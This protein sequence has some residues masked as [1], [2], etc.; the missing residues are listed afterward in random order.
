MIVELRPEEN[1]ILRAEDGNSTPM[2]AQ[3]SAPAIELEP[4]TGGT[5]TATKRGRA[6]EV[7]RAF[8]R[9]GCLSFGG[10][11]AHL[12][13][14][15]AEFVER[16]RWCDEE[17][18]GEVVALAQALPGPASS[19]VGFA[20]GVLRAGAAGGAAAWLGF[21]MPSALLMMGFAFGARLLTGRVGLGVVHGL[22]LVAVA[23]VAQALM[24]MRRSLAADWMRMLLAA[25][26]GLAVYFNLGTLPAIAMGAVAGLA[27][28]RGRQPTSADQRQMWGTNISFVASA[29]AAT[30]FVLLLFGLPVA[31]ALAGA[32]RAGHPLT[33]EELA[34]ANAFYRTGA[35]VF[36][37]GHVVLPLLERSVVQP[38]WVD[39]STFLAGYG[40]AQAVPGPLF[41]FSAFLGA[42]VKPA[43][44]PVLTA[45]VALA[46]IFLPGLLLMVAVLPHW[47][48]LRERAHVQAALR[49]VNAAVVGVLASAFVR[50]VWTSA[51]RSVFDL[52]IAAGAFAL[53]V[54]W[55]VAPWMMVTGV[56]AVSVIR[57]LLS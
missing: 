5:E 6:G 2:K 30:A 46:S 44:A 26:A 18:F 12:G 14:F 40:A 33:A 17:T 38:G 34:V 4:T 53:L 48:G 28:P 10:P 22:Q 13:Y 35:L 3:K 8:L 47:S 11:V 27:L 32:Q 37:G 52:A 31:A 9:L 45:A 57:A 49:G 42:S 36:G 43:M 39:E 41:T 56:A 55:R 50:P 29:L 21:T 1:E 24:A 20:L 51:V 19:Q 7:L 23:V 16:R 15:H 25:A 54:R